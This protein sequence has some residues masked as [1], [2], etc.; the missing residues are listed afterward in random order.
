MQLKQ[1]RNNVL[2]TTLAILLMGVV[3]VALSRGVIRPLVPF[4]S[5]TSRILYLSLGVV[6]L[7][8]IDSV[9]L[10]VRSAVHLLL[11]RRI[12]HYDVLQKKCLSVFVEQADFFATC[13]KIREILR[14]GFAIADVRLVIKIDGQYYQIDSDKYT[15][16]SHADLFIQ[17]WKTHSEQHLSH[18]EAVEMNTKSA[19][20]D[21]IYAFPLSIE[22]RFIGWISFHDARKGV[23]FFFEDEQFF[24]AIQPL[25]SVA[26]QRL[27]MEVKLEKRIQEL[28]AINHISQIM[29]SSLNSKE[30]LESVMDSVIRL[31]GADRALMY[32]S[33]DAGQFFS[34]VIG[35]GIAGDVNL[36][37]RI[38]IQKS[39]FQYVIARREPLIVEDVHADSRI[40]KEYAA[41]VKTRSFAAVPIVYKEHVLGIIG[42][43]NLTSGRSIHEI[44]VELLTA[45]A[46]HAATAIAN[47][48]LFEQ[49]QQFNTEL[50][51][52]IADA[53]V[54]LQKLVDMKSHFLTVASHQLRTPT[55]IVKGMLSMVV[56]DPDMPIA[57]Q[58]T[59]VAQAYASMNRLER[60]ISELLSATELEDDTVKVY[61]EVIDPEKLI[62][63]VI[64]NLSPLAKERKVD[65]RFLRSTPVRAIM[66][67]QFKLQE[68]LS[69]LVDNAIRYTK[70]G[71]VTVAFDYTDDQIVFSVT[72][73]G[74]GL[75]IEDKEIIFER[76]RRGE[77]GSNV[78][79][80]GTGLGLY[81]VKRIV[82]I[83]H[84]TVR[85]E[86]EGRGKGSVFTLTIPCG[87]EQEAT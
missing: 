18:A 69:N 47:S 2:Y 63:S 21:L 42:V 26:F 35:R 19:G 70:E 36:N 13:V 15:L 32:L 16:V 80:N 3:F 30:T 57:E 12:T 85:V 59:F 49:T 86:S 33:D 7:F 62:A 50:Q 65:L 54:H 17:F 45:L 22:Q 71:E 48:K 6:M 81:I 44:D 28:V 8:A 11:Q 40:N 73:T 23:R 34:P 41:Y 20:G 25:L 43:D 68:A 24:Q 61:P 78:E 1:F 9:R 83:L 31:T 4:G 82:E 58:R 14:K 66:A 46:N 64:A 67:D 38:D 37:F 72:D 76:F 60:I 55:T 74:I 5:W 10:F 77:E 87:N 56:E 75:T 79:P 53:T 39:V 27:R 51:K 52:K 84:G 29:N